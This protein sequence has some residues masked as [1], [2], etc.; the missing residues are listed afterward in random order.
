MDTLYRTEVLLSLVASHLEF[1]LSGKSTPIT[2]L[3][4]SATREPSLS[5]V[6]SR[7]KEA[8]ASTLIEPMASLEHLKLDILMNFDFASSQHA[9]LVLLGKK[10]R[11][12]ITSDNN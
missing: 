4:V 11:A 10:I 1:I 5:H 8:V 3:S 7:I 12:I 6:R 9:F 2:Q